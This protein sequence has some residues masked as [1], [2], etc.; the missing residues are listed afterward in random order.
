[1]KPED[2]I[3][4]LRNNM[5]GCYL[6]AVSHKIMGAANEKEIA[7]IKQYEDSQRAAQYRAS[8]QRERDYRES[9]EWKTA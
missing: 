1:M 4:A 6:L 7:F 5:R 8:L 2:Q 9:K 3:D